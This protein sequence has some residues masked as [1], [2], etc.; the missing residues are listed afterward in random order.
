MAHS[1]D[2][3][4]LRK[5][6]MAGTIQWQR[7]SLERM[8]ERGIATADVK[9]VL[10]QGEVIEDY[11]DAYP[12][13]AVLLLGRCGDRHLHVVAAVDGA[14]AMVYVITV[15]EPTLEHFEPDFRTRKKR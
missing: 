11:P 7:H 9:R 3:D 4:A 15:Y 10:R 6:A 14:A 2:L 12:L 13:P 1:L 8:A 5:A